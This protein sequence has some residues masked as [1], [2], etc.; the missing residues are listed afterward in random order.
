MAQGDGVTEDEREMVA[1]KPRVTEEEAA[2]LQALGGMTGEDDAALL[3]LIRYVEA[4]NAVPWDQ[5][6]CQEKMTYYT[7]RCFLVFL[8]TSVIFSL[9]L[10]FGEFINKAWWVSNWHKIKVF[11]FDFATYLFTQEEGKEMIEL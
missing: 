11:L 9:F 3:H 8:I 6:T 5:K 1:E 7:Y 10:L 4:R 2:L